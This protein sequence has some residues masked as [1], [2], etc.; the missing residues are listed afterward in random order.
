MVYIV[1]QLPW[2]LG[3][4]ALTP[5]NPEGMVTPKWPHNQNAYQNSL[6]PKASENNQ[7]LL[8]PLRPK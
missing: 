5:Q 3:P 4:V 8:E 7:L 6:T 2:D 1:T